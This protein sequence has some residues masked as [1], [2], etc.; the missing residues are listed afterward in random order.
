MVVVVG[1]AVISTGVAS[2]AVA[3]RWLLRQRSA[4]AH[5][6]GQQQ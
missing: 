6:A 5:T 3:I 4:G 2:I 1:I